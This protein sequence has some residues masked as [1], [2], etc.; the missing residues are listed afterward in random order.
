MLCMYSDVEYQ[1]FRLQLH[2]RLIINLEQDQN[3]LVAVAQERLHL[4]VTIFSSHNTSVELYFEKKERPVYTTFPYFFLHI[5]NLKRDH[6]INVNIC[7]ENFSL[8]SR[9]ICVHNESSLQERG[10]E[11]QIKKTPKHIKNQPQKSDHRKPHQSKTG[12]D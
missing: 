3:V 10:I 1:C 4:R 12:P 6:V 2:N 9:L 11:Y 5:S 8:V 7:V